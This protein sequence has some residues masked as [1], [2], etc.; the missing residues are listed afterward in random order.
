LEEEEQQAFE[1]LKTKLTTSP[2]LAYADLN[3]QLTITCDAS[4][5]AIGYILSPKDNQNR[6]RVIA[7]GG[8]SLSAT[9]RRYHTREKECLA[10]INVIKTNDT[11]V[12]DNYFVV[13]T[14]YQALCWLQNTKHKS[15]RLLRW[16]MALQHYDFEVKHIKGKDNTG[17]DALS[18]RTYADK[19]PDQDQMEDGPKI[20]DVFPIIDEPYNLTEVHFFYD[21]H[22]DTVLA[23]LH[24]DTVTQQI[25]SRPDLRELQRQCLD[26]QNIYAYLDQGILPDDNKLARKVNIES[27]QFSL[28]N[29]ILY[30]WYQR[31][32][33]KMDRQEAHHQQIALPQVLREEALTAYHDSE[34]GGAHLV[35]K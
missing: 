14:D 32:T 34:S 17:T 11:Y 12:S 29:N 27:Q 18:R 8:R 21:N 28:L 10:I 25:E 35:T 6:T 22:P 24:D 19:H 15:G 16:A 9:E 20:G 7:Y 5:T 26:F 2:I 30:H 1:E 33:N 3:R 13:L 4:N 23:A 31:R